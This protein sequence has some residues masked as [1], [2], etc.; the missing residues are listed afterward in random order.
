MS[1]FFLFQNLGVLDARVYDEYRRLVPA[2]VERHG[3]LYRVLG[4][5]VEPVEGL[6]SLTS[7]VMI[8]FP[9][10]AA[11]RRWYASDEYQPLKQARL[12]AV[13]TTGVLVE[14]L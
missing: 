12:R 9:S 4:G 1:A 13:R 10:L 6:F 14:G 2:T 8:E 11:A 7:P 5:S 3:G